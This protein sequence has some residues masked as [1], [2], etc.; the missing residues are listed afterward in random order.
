MKKLSFAYIPS[1]KT[2]CWS[3][4]QEEDEWLVCPAV[5]SL[6]FKVLELDWCK[7]SKG[8][9]VSCSIPPGQWG[10]TDMLAL[11]TGSSMTIG[12]LHKITE[13]QVLSTSGEIKNQME[14]SSRVMVYKWISGSDT[15]Q[16]YFPATTGT[17]ISKSWTHSTGNVQQLC[18]Q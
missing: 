9:D 12:P 13:K 17:C 5:F 4:W 6:S 8:V 1:G 2:S 14:V 16:N 15:P 18:R 3:P 11:P 10:S 7:D